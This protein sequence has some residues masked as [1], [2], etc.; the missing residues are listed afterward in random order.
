MKIIAF[1]SF[2]CSTHFLLKSQSDGIYIVYNSP[3]CEMIQFHKNQRDSI[4]F[5]RFACQEV[6]CNVKSEEFK[7]AAK[8]FKK[9]A[10][11]KNSEDKW[12]FLETFQVKTQIGTLPISNVLKIKVLDANSMELSTF[13]EGDMK[14]N[15][16]TLRVLK[17]IN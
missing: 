16:K 10:I 6:N 1:L 7:S 11:E 9:Y 14:A 13:M 5:N 12:V 15:F 3:F 4:T 17:R 8:N 2:F